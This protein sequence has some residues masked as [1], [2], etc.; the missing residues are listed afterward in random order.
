[1]DGNFSQCVCTCILRTEHEVLGYPSN[2]TIYDSADSKSLVKTIINSLGLDDKTYK[3][4]T[5]AGEYRW[6]KTT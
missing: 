3:P 4:G 5:V 1:M 2:F 6:Q